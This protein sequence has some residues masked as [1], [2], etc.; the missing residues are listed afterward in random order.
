MPHL[1]L[2]VTDYR[3]ETAWRWVLE[4]A[5]GNFLAD[6][7]VALDREAKGARAFFDLPGYLDHYRA[8]DPSDKLLAEAGAWIGEHVLGD[9]AAALA[10][11]LE[12]PATAVRVWVKPSPAVMR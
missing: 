11:K 5:A 7:E 9:V 12:P 3:D 4:D 6:H 8:I 2:R 10:T 1:Q